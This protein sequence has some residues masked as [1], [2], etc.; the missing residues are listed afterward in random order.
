MSPGAILR[1]PR[2]EG[3][4]ANATEVSCLR[5]YRKQTLRL[6]SRLVTDKACHLCTSVFADAPDS[7]STTPPG[8]LPRPARAGRHRLS[9]VC[10]C[11]AAR[12]PPRHRQMSPRT[13][14][15]PEKPENEP[16]DLTSRLGAPPATQLRTHYAPR[17]S[18]VSPNTSHPRAFPRAGPSVPKAGPATAA[19]L[20]KLTGRFL[21]EAF[22]DA[23]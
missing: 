13:R 7:C 23:V 4:T 10:A 18:A 6:Q 5:S 12:S 15:G 14:L 19:G 2:G 20:S 9:A 1:Y 21:Q 16:R 11:A 3:N 22:P 8:P 17:T